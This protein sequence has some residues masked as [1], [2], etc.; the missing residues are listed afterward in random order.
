MN[1]CFFKLYV[2]PVTKGLSR[3]IKIRQYTLARHNT[4]SCL[5]AKRPTAD[6]PFLD[7]LDQK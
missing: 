7:N 1:A 6:K 2:S 5:N 4:V 3:M